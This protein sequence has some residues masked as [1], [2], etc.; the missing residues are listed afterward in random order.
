MTDLRNDARSISRLLGDAFEQLSHLVQTEIRLA[1]AELAD[2][3]AQAGMGVGLLAGGLLFMIPALVLLLIAFA[4]FLT[5]LGLSPVTAHLL[6]GLAG[7]VI[8]GIL[9]MLGLARLKPS[10]LTPD[11]TIRQVQ[12]DIAAAKEIAR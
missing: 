5:G 9:I 8:A 2:K 6:A 1:R 11:T 7:A 4:L 3:A 12:K 10:S